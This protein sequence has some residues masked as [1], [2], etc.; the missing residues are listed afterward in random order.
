MRTVTSIHRLRLGLLALVAAL[1]AVT[2]VAFGYASTQTPAQAQYA[3]AN[4][5]PPTVSDKKAVQ[6]QEL[7][8]DPGTWTGDQ[9]I[10][11]SFQWLRCDKDGNNCV[12]IPNA[13]Q[14]KYT[15]Q[16]AD[17]GNRLRVTVTGANASGTG[18]PAT[19]DK[20][21]AVKAAPVTP[22]PPPKGST[23]P[24]TDVSLPDRLVASEVRFSPSPIRSRTTPVTVRVRILDTRGYVISGALVFARSTPLVTDS[25]AEAT[26]GN[27]GWA[28]VVLRPRSNF[29][30]LAR[31]DNLQVFVRARKP[32]GDLL[33]GISTRRLVQVRVS[34]GF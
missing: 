11:F 31:Q 7:S 1:G 9:P 21:D 22:P 24:V 25:S 10:V 5:K 6:G 20:T 33:A 2:F 26:T 8:A 28:T 15:P 29:R 16:A 14:Q 32:G 12:G 17:V 34:S 3:P 23:I 30:I 18:S 27:D 19:S 4:T 13:T